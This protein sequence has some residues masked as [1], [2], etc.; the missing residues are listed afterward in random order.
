[1]MPWLCWA[2]SCA[3]ARRVPGAAQAVTGELDVQAV[4]DRRDEIIG[5][6]DDSRQ[7]GWLES[8]GVTLVRGHGRLDGER[9]V[10]VGERVLHS[11][12]AVVI[13]TGRGAGIPI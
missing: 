4:L 10:H 2:D 3:E 6:L 11:L 5:G 9:R 8:R 13:A 12:P 7:V 1:M